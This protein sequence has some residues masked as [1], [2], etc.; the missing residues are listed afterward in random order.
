MCVFPPTWHLKFTFQSNDR[1]TCS[2]KIVERFC[3]PLAPAL[4]GFSELWVEIWGQDMGREDWSCHSGSELQ[5]PPPQRAGPLSTAPWLGLPLVRA[6]LLLSTRRGLAWLCGWPRCWPGCGSGS[7]C[8]GGCWECGPCLGRP[9]LPPS[10]LSQQSVW[11]PDGP[12]SVPESW[13]S[14]RAGGRG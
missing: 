5:Q 10:F 6:L 8:G 12:S 14:A 4:Q 9:L 2:C 7:S 3:T 1:D 13:S 11:A